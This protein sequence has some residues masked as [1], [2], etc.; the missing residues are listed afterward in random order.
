M[1]TCTIRRPH[2]IQADIYVCSILY[3]A[4]S[5]KL[6]TLDSAWRW[7]SEASVCIFQCLTLM[8]I[9]SFL[10]RTVMN[11][12]LLQSLNLDKHLLLRLNPSVAQ[13]Q[14][15]LTLVAKQC[16]S[17]PD[18]C[19]CMPNPLYQGMFNTPWKMKSCPVYRRPCRR[20]QLY[21]SWYFFQYQKGFIN[22]HCTFPPAVSKLVHSSASA[23]RHIF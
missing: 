1:P 6:Y 9:L 8:S 10:P 21:L 18:C 14:R 4:A 7:N 5:S 13:L 19:I 16:C 15:K 2:P 22:A 11:A 12:G 17:Q 3:N 23:I 20:P